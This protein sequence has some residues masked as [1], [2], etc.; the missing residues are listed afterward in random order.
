MR[1]ARVVYDPPGSDTENGETVTVANHGSRAQL[2]GFALRDEAGARYRLPAYRIR[3]ND[4]VLI[5]SGNGSDRRG[6][7][8]AGWGY[9]WNNTGD[10]AR[11]LAPGGR[12]VDRCSWGD[13]RGTAAC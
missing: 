10:T 3:R 5:H 8:Y 7:L 1:I 11:L 6:H 13:G 12:V 2:R 9:T 4:R